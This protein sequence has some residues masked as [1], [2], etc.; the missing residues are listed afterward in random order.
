MHNK[1]EWIFIID[2]SQKSCF[3]TAPN[4]QIIIYGSQILVSHSNIDRI[5]KDEVI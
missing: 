3:Q 4:D 5:G 2:C 1:C